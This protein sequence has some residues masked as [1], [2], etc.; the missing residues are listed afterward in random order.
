MITEPKITVFVKIIY[1][2][3]L[4][5]LFF[6][7][8]KHYAII[9]VPLYTLSS[10]EMIYKRK[11]LVFWNSKKS[12]LA[13][14]FH[15]RTTVYRFVPRLMGITTLS[16]SRTVT[17]PSVTNTEGTGEKQSSSTGNVIRTES[18]CQEDGVQIPIGC[19]LNQ[20]F[21]IIHTHVC[22]LH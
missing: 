9:I 21:S 13:N 8:Y 18:I 20:M 16:A 5:V 22:L 14:Y 11:I 7:E 6:H 10:V 3:Y 12:F 19:L 2:L 4:N 1:F 17:F 15:F